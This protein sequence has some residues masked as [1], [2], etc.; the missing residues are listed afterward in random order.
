MQNWFSS[1][2]FSFSKLSEL[3]WGRPY[4]LYLLLLVPLIFVLKSL[5]KNRQRQGLPIATINGELNLGW[6]RYFRFLP[7]I[8][9]A[10][11]IALMIVALARPQLASK[12]QNRFSE[13]IDI[14]L[15]IDISESMLT[16][17]IAPNRLEASK[18]I[19]KQF[20]TNRYQDRIGLVVFSGEAY[21]L[22]PLTTDYEALNGFVDEIKPQLISVEGTA[23][24]SAIAVSVNRL[25][26]SKSKSKVIIL[27]SDGDNTAGNL[28]PITSAQIANAYGVKCYTILVGD[29]AQKGINNSISDTYDLSID[30]KALSDIAKTADGKFFMASNMKSLSAVFEQINQLEK[31]KFLENS[32]FEMIDVF[33]VYLKWGIVFFILA[34]ATKITFIGNILED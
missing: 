4:F 30:Q 23:I 21:T 13:G 12:I 17:D 3:T 34:F 6:S 14:M 1:N 33:H 19:T 16:K 28:D 22:S 5:F 26:K 10:I 2:W 32:S 27:I 25:Q 15:A 8:L 24:G 20:I 31:I 9:Q 7:P 18:S 11:S 29:A